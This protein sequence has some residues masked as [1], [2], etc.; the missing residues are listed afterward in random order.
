MIVVGLT[1]NLASGKSAAA[2]I[3]KKLGAKVLDADQVAKK[4]T[5]KGT[6][7]YKAIV[8]IFGT[9]YLTDTKDLDRRRLAW[10]V[11]TRPKELKKL[12]ILIHP[13]V[14][15][16][17]FKAIE[18]EKGK[19]GMLVLDVPLLFESHMEK[20]VDVTVVV[21]SDRETTLKR[22]AKRGVPKKLA[23]KIL[24]SQW[25]LSKK[26]KL[27]DYVVENNGTPA[28]LEAQIKKVYGEIRKI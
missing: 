13:G 1:G 24:A 21:K 6:P 14:I 19:K 20:I 26:S 9:A 25:P 3:F 23:K 2:G 22:A 11:F 7:L 5:Q 10:H 8:K 12:N 28:E 4:L 18:K 17:A 15:V 27:A 16:E